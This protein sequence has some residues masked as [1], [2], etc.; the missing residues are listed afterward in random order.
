MSDGQVARH[1]E[2]GFMTATVDESG[3]PATREPILNPVDRIS[4]I[5]FGL[6]MALTFVLDTLIAGIRGRLVHA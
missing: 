1:D 6:F 4:E 5:L 2:H 3:V